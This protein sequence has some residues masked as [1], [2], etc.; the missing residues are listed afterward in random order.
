M[1]TTV[2]PTVC[3]GRTWASLGRG[4]FLDRAVARMILTVTV[5]CVT[6]QCVTV[7]CVAAPCVPRVTVPYVSFI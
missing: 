4:G 3:G 7:P 5:P 1:C 6:V 2:G